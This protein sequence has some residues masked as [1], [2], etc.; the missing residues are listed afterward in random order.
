MLKNTDDRGSSINLTILNYLET[1][2][3]N[4]NTILL[5]YMGLNR[6]Q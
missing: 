4:H 1:I 2:G 5:N 3:S 6:A